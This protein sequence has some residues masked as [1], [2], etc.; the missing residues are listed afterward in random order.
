VKLLEEV[1]AIISKYDLKPIIL[2][3]RYKNLYAYFRE[4]PLERVDYRSIKDDDYFCD[5]YAPHIPEGWYGF[6]IGSPI[7]LG[8]MEILDE[9]LELCIKTDPKFEIYQIKMKYGG[10]RF[11]TGSHTIEDIGDIESI[12]E[13]TLYNKALIY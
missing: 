11:Y 5:K 6:A 7:I 8:W 10:I 4:F 12:I 1:K 13:D 3:K 2:P 9:I